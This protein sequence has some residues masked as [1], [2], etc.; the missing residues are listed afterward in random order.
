VTSPVHTLELAAGQLINGT[1]ITLFT[2]PAGFVYVPTCIDFTAEQT[3]GIHRQVSGKVSQDITGDPLVLAFVMVLATQYCRGF[4]H[5][6]GRREV[7]EGATWSGWKDVGDNDTVSFRITGY[8]L[9][10]P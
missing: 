3:E 5:W 10:L 2:V 9:T 4:W 7:P 6:Q 1:W 8:K